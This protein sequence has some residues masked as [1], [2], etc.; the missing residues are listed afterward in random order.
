[1][2]VVYHREAQDEL[3]AQAQFYEHRQPGLGASFLAAVD[4][5]I[6]RIVEQSTG[7]AI[8]E[9][10]V[11]RCPVARFPFDVYFRVLDEEIRILVI[12]HERRDPNYWKHRR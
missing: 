9:E 7:M 1:M 12:M 3:I 10:D 11:R 5:A 2:Q 6:E 8:V 4:S